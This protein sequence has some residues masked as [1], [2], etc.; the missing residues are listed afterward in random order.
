MALLDRLLLGVA[1]ALLLVTSPSLLLLAV[2]LLLFCWGCA[3]TWLGT[4]TA[5]APRRAE[6]LNSNQKEGFIS[7]QT[8]PPA[9]NKLNGNTS[10]VWAALTLL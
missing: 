3:K 1:P 6:R 8:L 10:E 9:D 2:L 5:V 7:M 4:A